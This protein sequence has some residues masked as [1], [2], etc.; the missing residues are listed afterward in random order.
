VSVDITAAPMSTWAYWA[1]AKSNHAGRDI[2][3]VERARRG[4]MAA[5]DI[6]LDRSAQS[7]Y[8]SPKHP[9]IDFTG[10]YNFSVSPIAALAL[11]QARHLSGEPIY[12][13]VATQTADIILGANP[14]SRVYLTGIGDAPVHDPMDRISLNDA[15]PEPLRGLTV[16]GPT[17]HLPAYREP[18]DSVNAAYWPP[19]QPTT[20]GD[21]RSAYPSLRRWIDAFLD[22]KQFP[23]ASARR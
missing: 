4:L 11:L 5:A 14:Q 2:L 6:K 8:R 22:G 17:W 9:A 20:D 21:Y 3:L 13:D 18:Y 16:A 15:N 19:E 7:S 23:A 1:I 12:L 10:W